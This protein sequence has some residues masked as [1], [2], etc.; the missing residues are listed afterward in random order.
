MKRIS[1]FILS[2]L[3]CI[4]MFGQGYETNF[5]PIMTP[6]AATL[7]KFGAYPVSH[8]TG[9]VDIKIPIYTDIHRIPNIIGYVAVCYSGFMMVVYTLIHYV[10]YIY[11]LVT[12]HQLRYTE[13][14]T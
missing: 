4:G 11:N 12:G 6:E 13:N 3:T 10:I 1:I 7:G 5:F 2:L 8:Y 14:V 9:S